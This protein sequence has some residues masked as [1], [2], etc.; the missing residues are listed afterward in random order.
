MPETRRGG[1][2]TDYPPFRFDVPA[3]SPNGHRST[4]RGRVREAVRGVPAGLLT[5]TFVAAS[6]V[7]RLSLLNLAFFNPWQRPVIASG[8]GGLAAGASR[9]GRVWRACLVGALCALAGLWA[10]YGVTRVQNPVLFV[11]RDPVHVILSDLARLAAYALPAG[12]AGAL[13][14]ALLRALLRRR[15]AAQNEPITEL[16]GFER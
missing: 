11:M 9:G 1:D 4:R 7:P 5:S 10:V 3:P 6:I 14:G 2:G 8:V 16:P 12:A 13:T 15:K